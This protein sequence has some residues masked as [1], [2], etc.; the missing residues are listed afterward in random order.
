VRTNLAKPPKLVPLCHATTLILPCH[1]F[2]RFL[3]PHC[4]HAATTL[5]T[6]QYH[7][8]T[9]SGHR[10]CTA[11]RSKNTTNAPLLA[12]ADEQF[13][14]WSQGVA[15]FGSALLKTYFAEALHARRPQQAMLQVRAAQVLTLRCMCVL[16][17]CCSGVC[18]CPLKP[19]LHAGSFYQV[20]AP[21]DQACMRA[22]WTRFACMLIGQNFC[23]L[24]VH[25]CC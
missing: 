21:L 14:P 5:P 12:F 13:E 24:D 19:R 9:P 20:Y 3:T 8:G 10:A 23:S 16:P 17:R 18:A 4:H 11:T 6:P 15:H 7:Y 25:A 2:T 1:H 22:P